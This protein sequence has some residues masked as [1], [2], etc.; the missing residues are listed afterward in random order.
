MVCFSSARRVALRA[1]WH[2]TRAETRPDGETSSR[3]IVLRR[4]GVGAGCIAHGYRAV[5]PLSRWCHARADQAGAMCDERRG[6][7]V[8]QP[9]QLSRAKRQTPPSHLNTHLG[10]CARARRIGRR[11]ADSD[12]PSQDVSQ[13][14]ARVER[15]GIAVDNRASRHSVE[16]SRSRSNADRQKLHNT[17][18]S[19]GRRPVWPPGHPG[20]APRLLACLFR[21]KLNLQVTSSQHTHTARVGRPPCACDQKSWWARGFS[22][23]SGRAAAKRPSISLPMRICGRIRRHESTA[24]EHERCQPSLSCDCCSFTCIADFMLCRAVVRTKRRRRG[25][26]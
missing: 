18:R 25:A 7:A 19:C 3:H 17:S 10:P 26:G 2:S 14:R 21:R 1:Q 15:P 6:R 13:T 22:R 12:S 11:S 8:L 24:E 16:R 4:N 5:S 23:R 20:L 9:R